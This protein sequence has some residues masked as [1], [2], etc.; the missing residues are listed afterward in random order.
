[1]QMVCRVVFAYWS[2]FHA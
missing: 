1:M 2:L